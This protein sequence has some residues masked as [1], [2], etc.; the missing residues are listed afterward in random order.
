[1]PNF[2]RKTRLVRKQK[3][4]IT[5]KTVF[6]GVFTVGLVVVLAIWGLPFLVRLALFLGDI[7]K[8]N[9]VTE[10]INE[11]IPPLPPRLF[12]PYEATNSSSIALTGVSQENLEVELIQND[13]SVAKVT[14]DEE[15]E[16]E[17]RLVDLSLGENRF[18]AFCSNEQGQTSQSSDELI[19]IYDDQVP[20]LEIFS[21]AEESIKV[22][23]A[24][25]E[26]TGKTEAG[27]SVMVKGRVA[28][29]NSDGSF[30]VIV[31]LQEGDNQIEVVAVD[32]AGN[33]S[34]KEY[35]INLVL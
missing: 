17:F 32:M 29:V 9:E 16:F 4:K 22:E 20:E 35:K 23:E 25:Y 13:S 3:E 34:R 8:N 31:A 1:M 15:G 27:V 24:D 2:K 5:R 7:K 26:V 21:P 14:A 19:V 11:G 30:K 10:Q 6:L 33:I 18:V 28:I 12:L